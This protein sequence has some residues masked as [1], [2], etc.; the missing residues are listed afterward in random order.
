VDRVSRFSCVSINQ[1]V[2]KRGVAIDR[3]IDGRQ[4]APG[5]RNAGA[6]GGL[7]AS[8]PNN[9]PQPFNQPTFP[10]ESNRLD[11]GREGVQA[12]ISGGKG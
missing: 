1:S 7:E 12:W 9:C 2:S 11:G 8:S 10:I 6:V 3:S 4:T 5:R